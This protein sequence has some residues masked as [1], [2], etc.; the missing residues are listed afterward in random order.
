MAGNRVGNLFVDRI[1]R[2]DAII[3]SEVDELMKIDE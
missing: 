1:E 2:R 3:R